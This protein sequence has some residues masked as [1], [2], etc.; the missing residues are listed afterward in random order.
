MRSGWA[1]LALAVLWLGCVTAHPVGS[2]PQG[3][4]AETV[5]TESQALAV[6]RA[7]TRSSDS[8]T[9][10]VAASAWIG[11]AHPS[12]SVLG[13]WVLADPSPH[14]QRVS[15]RA[16][17]RVGVPLTVHPGTDTLAALWMGRSGSVLSDEHRTLA[18]AIGGDEVGLSQ[19]LSDL[20]EG[21]ISAESDVLDLLIRSDLR[22]VGD[23]LAQG[24]ALA[25]EPIRLPMA[26]AAVALGSDNGV[27]AVVAL[28]KDAPGTEL[29][30]EAVEAMVRLGGSRAE[31]WLER[32]AKGGSEAVAMHAKIGL[33]VSGQ[34]SLE[35][36]AGALDSPDRD[37]RAWA[38]QCV[39]LA[40][41]ERPLPRELITRLQGRARDEA[42]A[43][44]WGAV[45]A[46]LAVAGPGAV[47][48]E[49]PNP[50]DELD[51]VSM[52][53]AAKWL[54]GLAEMGDESST[55]GL[56]D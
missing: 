36:V 30:I 7:G 50:D 41:A 28:L 27:Q 40:V 34:T 5:W 43:V 22:G 2:G 10:A 6:L 53:I 38:A 12:S 15:A 9:R 48:M 25:E 51:A 44:R 8:S 42:P 47:L 13:G 46:L 49:S 3:K 4:A 45:E 29:R 16:A 39:S 37:T 26:M 24:A 17:S 33:V 52:L 56:A 20:S 35:F 55:E 31:R 23:A 11:S 1:V 18:L 54:E 32:A 21:T 14:V 19:L